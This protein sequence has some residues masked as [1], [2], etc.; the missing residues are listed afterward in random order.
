MPKNDQIKKVMVIGSGPI[1]IGQ[2]AEF[3][4]AGTQACRALKQENIE[5]VLVNSNPATIMTDQDM[6]SQVYLEPLQADAIQNILLKENCDALLATLGGQTAINLAMELTESGFLSEHKIKLLGT[7]AEGIKRGE[8]RELF[9]DAMLKIGVTCIPSGIAHTLTESENLAEEIGYPVIVRPA[10]TLGGTGGGIVANKQ[11]LREIAATGLEVSRVHQVLI[12]KAIAGWK[13]IEYEVVRDSAGNAIII[14]SMENFDPVGVHTGDSIVMAP[15]LT[16]SETEYEM[17]RSAALRIVDELKIE[18]GCNVQFALH[19]TSGE[20]AVIEVNPRLSRSSA[21]AS[22]ASGYPIAKVATKIALGYSLTEIRNEITGKAWAAHEPVLDYVVTKIPKWPFDKFVHAK[23]SLGTQMKATGEVMAIACTTE[24]SLLKAIRSLELGFNTLFQESLT[25]LEDQEILRIIAE[26]DDRRLFYL[27]EAIRRGKS[28]AELQQL[29]KIDLYFLETVK[30]IVDLESAL[31]ELRD[32]SALREFSVVK[33]NQENTNKLLQNVQKL[34]SL[35]SKSAVWSFSETGLSEILQLDLTHIKQIW[36][37]LGVEMVYR[38]VDTGAGEITA[39]SPYYFGCLTKRS[40]DKVTEDK[41][42]SV[43]FNNVE[44]TISMSDNTAKKIVVLGSG[45]IRIGQGIEFDYCSVHCAQALRESGY[46]SIIINNNPETVSTD[47]DTSDRLYFEPLTIDDVSR[48]LELEKPQG[49]ICQFGGQTAIKLIQAVTDLGYKILGTSAD[50]VDRAEDR[51]RFDLVLEE[52]ELPRPKADAVFTTEEA[53]KAAEELGYPV[54]LRPSYVLGGQGMSICHNEQA[55][56]SYMEIINL[57]TQEHPIL[58]D[59]YLMGTEL[60]VDAISDGKQVLIPGIMEHLERAGVHSGDSISIFPAY[61]PKS[62]KEKIV[63]YTE[64]LAKALKIIG[65]INI[66]FILYNYEVYVLEVNPRSSRTVP[67]ISKV[68]GLPIV[69]LATRVMLGESFADLNIEPGLFADYPSVYAI[70][71]P[72]FS[73]EKLH[74]VDTTL[75]PEMKSTGEVLGLSEYYPEA[76]YKAILASGFKFPTPGS[77]ILMLVS[78]ADK[79]E[80][81]PLAKRLYDLGFDLYATGGTANYLNRY[82][83]ATSVVRREGNS[84]RDVVSFLK[85]GKVKLLINTEIPGK[86]RGLGFKVRR[87]AI[88]HGIATLTSLDTLVAVTE[89]LEQGLAAKD[90]L[91]YSIADFADIVSKTRHLTKP[92]NEMNQLEKEAWQK[93]LLND[94]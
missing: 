56:V 53:L 35:I 14:C 41:S 86:R 3:D 85:S 62:V 4:Y 52:C 44:E 63:T 37:A 19:P 72:V 71:A 17:L 13:E 30:N 87:L 27:A 11:E 84:S 54:L 46:Q 32:H 67:Y 26:V 58:I 43:L 73:F 59:K 28:L 9:R 70:K 31:L 8:D 45:P 83:I 93:L 69:D 42:D 51:A 90:L 77:A 40:E 33:P 74:D 10:F 5:T 48:I 39:R 82:G 38:A 2:A 57:Q 34:D 65:L 61:I 55:I 29:T 16:L 89:C 49:V 92:V 25:E 78:D 91:A 94:D 24:G 64:R 36:Q 18:G 80:L 79:A 15:A 47:F 12:E 88:E 60:E 7:Q 50:D 6:A 20:Y 68:T 66:Q 1:I 75:G 22:K 21:L 76:M 23:R 81:V